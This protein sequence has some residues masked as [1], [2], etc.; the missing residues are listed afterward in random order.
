MK[1]AV[2]VHD[3]TEPA[4][5]IE[6][7]IRDRDLPGV[8]VRLDETN[9]LPTGLDNSALVL[10]GGPMSVN[11]ETVYPWLQSEKSLVRHA[12]GAGRP[13][14]GICLGAQLIASALG[15]RVYPSEREVGWRT[16]RG[17]APH[18]LFPEAFPAFELHGETFDLPDGARLIATAGPVPHQAFAFGSAIGTQFHLEC[19]ASTIETWTSSLASATRE[20]LADETARHLATSHRLCRDLLDHVLRR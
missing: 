11:D 7:W 10:M 16:I 18:A 9:E 17:L 12:V 20:R 8:T 14:L 4:G 15:A 1:I 19:T 3:A 5:V 13:V 6:E 2:V